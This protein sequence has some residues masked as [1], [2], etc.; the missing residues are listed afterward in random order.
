[1]TRFYR[2]FLWLCVLGVA[3]MIFHFSAQ[4]GAISSSTSGQ[5]VEKVIDVLDE[6][7]D[8]RPPAAQESI[9]SFV[10]HLVRKGAHFLEYAALGV[11][12]RLLVHAYAWHPPTRLSLLI[13]TLYACTDE[14]HQLFISQRNA[15]CQDVLLDSVGVLFGLCAARLLIYLLKRWK[16]RKA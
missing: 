14:L 8:T 6:E 4:E 10:E 16:E 13:G 5:I 7:Y 11:F 9:F 1:M 3:G 2:I 12:L 15:Q